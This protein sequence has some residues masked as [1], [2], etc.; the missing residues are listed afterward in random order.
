MTKQ[1][2]RGI[3]NNN[4]MNIRHGN[5]WQGEILG[6]DPAFESFKSPEYGI[7]AGC[8]LFMNYQ[9]KYKL[10]SIRGLIGR[11]A[12]PNENDTEAY[13]KA[14]ARECGTGTDTQVMLSANLEFFVNFVTAVI[15]HENGSVPY[16]REVIEAGV[17][18]ALKR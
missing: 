7:R 16:D 10:D 5:D 14:V 2:P 17:L 13:V 15:R 6:N 4:P 3:R 8:V 9:K 11:W 18:M 1:L 12:P